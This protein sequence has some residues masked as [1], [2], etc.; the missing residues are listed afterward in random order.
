MKIFKQQ[1]IGILGGGQLGRMLIQSGLD[2][3]LNFKVLDPDK[4]APC[5]KISEFVH[6]DF[7]DFDS[8][9]TF[10]EDC[11]VVTIEIESVNTE[12][13]KKLKA[14]GKKVYPQPEVIEVIQDKIKQKRF[15]TENDIP[16]SE[17]KV[18]NNS[19]EVKSSNIEFPYVQKLA[20]GGYD[21]KGVQIIRNDEDLN[22]LFDEPCVV[23]K[24]IDIDKEI[25]VIV[26]RSPSGEVKSFPVVEMVFHPE[27]N[28]VD[29][30][31]SPASLS[32]EQHIRAKELAQR[33]ANNL[34]IVGLLA[35]EMFLTSEGEII[36]NESAP[37]PHNSG[38]QTIEG[39][40]TSQFQQHIRAI[41]DLPLGDVR[42]EKISAMINLLGEKGYEGETAYSGFEE[43]LQQSNIHIHSYA[44]KKTRPFRKMGHATIVSDS[45]VDI[46]NQIDYIRETFKIISK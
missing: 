32:N 7:T 3:G 17:F 33:L 46:E 29:Y 39:N 34:G 18:F 2:Y 15:Y 11:D 13:L 31:I 5:S 1:K 36:V 23:E 37:R 9:L 30:L 42:A 19:K 28:L 26:A 38:H 10:A 16:T 14:S 27:H 4:E 6:G 45:R 35:V 24:L 44:K 41:L 21:G 25:S 20:T 22:K 43:I 8:V 40:L 12:A